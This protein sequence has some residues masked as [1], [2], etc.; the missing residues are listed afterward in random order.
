[1]TTLNFSQTVFFAHACNVSWRLF[2]PRTRQNCPRNLTFRRCIVSLQRLLPYESERSAP[3]LFEVHVFS[4]RGHGAVGKA[5]VQCR[6]PFRWSL[7]YVALTRF[8]SFE[9]VA[10]EEGH[11]CLL[12]RLEHVNGRGDLAACP[13]NTACLPAQ[14]NRVHRLVDKVKSKA[15]LFRHFE[16]DSVRASWNG[17]SSLCTDV[18]DKRFW[19]F[20]RINV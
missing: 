20:Y 18:D 7:L 15:R 11:D 5:S 2:T 8:C 4:S 12:E 1:M 19:Y 9:G 17:G 3:T 6:T 16:Q 13:A 10:Y 14:L